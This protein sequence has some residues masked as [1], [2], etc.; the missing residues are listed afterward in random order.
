MKK[1]INAPAMVTFKLAV[2][3]RTALLEE[4]IEMAN[5][6][7]SLGRLN[8]MDTLVAMAIKESESLILLL[9]DVLPFLDDDHRDYAFGRTERLSK[10]RDQLQ[11]QREDIVL[12][13]RLQLSRALNLAAH[14]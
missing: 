4:T 11:M 9:L 6:A 10:Q 2:F 3:T 1:E 12:A 5:S 7:G 14:A 13:R 8:D